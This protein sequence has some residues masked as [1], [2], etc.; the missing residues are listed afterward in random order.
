MKKRTLVQEIET[1]FSY[2][3]QKEDAKGFIKKV[4]SFV[5]KLLKHNW[6]KENLR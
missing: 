2:R 6:N 4:K 5:E 1:V 3:Q